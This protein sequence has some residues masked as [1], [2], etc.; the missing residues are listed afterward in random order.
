MNDNSFPQ[1][2]RYHYLHEPE[3]R[4]RPAHGV[5]GGINA[6]GEVEMCFYDES[7][8]P[9]EITEQT[10]GPDG[11]PGPEQICQEDTVRHMGKT[12]HTRILLNYHTARAVLEWLQDRVDEL[13]AEEG[14]GLYDLGGGVQQ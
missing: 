12:I 8:I 7:D 4:L 3:A 10:I 5:W 6:H 11:I 14:G 9:P 1:R 13:E 2:I